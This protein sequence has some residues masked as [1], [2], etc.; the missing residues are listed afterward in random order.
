M[1]GVGSGRQRHALDWR[2]AQEEVTK[3]RRM[4]EDLL[5]VAVDDEEC[6]VDELE[7]RAIN[8]EINRKMDALLLMLERDR[9]R[10][11]SPEI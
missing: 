8:H 9:H 1:N 4:Q 3:L 11:S 6:G 5:L 10:P 2:R 7:L